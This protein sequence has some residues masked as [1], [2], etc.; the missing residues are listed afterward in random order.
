[1]DFKV[2]TLLKSSSGNKKLEHV[3]DTFEVE[4][5]RKNCDIEGTVLLTKTDVGIWVSAHLM[6]NSIAEC[7]SCLLYTSPS[8]RD[9]TLSRM[10]SSA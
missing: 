7:G 6:A 1:M 4:W 5:S 3:K 10:P 8:P 9:A 2:A